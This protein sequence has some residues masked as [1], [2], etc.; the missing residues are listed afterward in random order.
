MTLDGQTQFAG[1]H[2]FAVVFDQDKIGAAAGCGDVDAACAGIERILHQ[3]LNCTG[4]TLDHLAGSDAVD[5][6]FA[7]PA[8]PAGRSRVGAHSAD[9][10]KGGCLAPR[11]TRICQQAQATYAAARSTT[12]VDGRFTVTT[13]P[14]ATALAMETEPPCSSASAFTIASPRPVPSSS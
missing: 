10:S 11:G 8:N 6:T 4:R 7:K 2:P 5:G 3:F 14:F 13:V 9:C 1:I 12:R